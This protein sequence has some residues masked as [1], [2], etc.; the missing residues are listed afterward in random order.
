MKRLGFLV[1]FPLVFLLSSCR[2]QAAA[3]VAL[4]T[5]VPAATA[6]TPTAPPMPTP[7]PTHGPTATSTPTVPPTPTA[8]PTVVLPVSNGTPLPPLAPIGDDWGKVREV[9]QYAPHV[10]AKVVY[11]GKYTV[12]VYWKNLDIVGEDGRVVAHVPLRVNPAKD[13]V[14]TGNDVVAVASANTKTIHV[15][16]WK[17]KEI[18]QI[19]PH[20]EVQEVRVSP[21]GTLVAYTTR[22]GYDPLDWWFYVVSV[23]D[24]EVR[25]RQ[26][27]MGG[28]QFSEDGRYFAVFFDRRLHVYDVRSGRE[29]YNVWA[30][31][32]DTYAFSPNGEKVAVYHPASKTVE[33]YDHGELKR[34]I[35]Q[36]RWG[37]QGGQPVQ[38]WV[39]L[40]FSQ[41]GDVLAVLYTQ[42]QSRYAIFDLTT[43][44]RLGQAAVEGECA[45]WGI[46]K[47]YLVCKRAVGTR[48]L[49]GSPPQLF[50][51]TAQGW[52]MEWVGLNR[53]LYTKGGEIDCRSALSW[54]DETAPLLKSFG[55]PPWQMPYWLGMSEDGQV[56]GA[57][58]VSGRGMNT[59]VLVQTS[60]KRR[61][62]AHTFANHSFLG[63]PPL[64][65]VGYALAPQGEALALVGVS[66]VLDDLPA[67]GEVRFISLKRGIKLDSL[68]IP[69]PPK[70]VWGEPH[71]PIAFCGLNYLAVAVEGKPL[72]IYNLQ[73][74]KVV[75]ALKGLGAVHGLTCGQNALAVLDA[76]MVLHVYGIPALDKTENNP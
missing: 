19:T 11:S 26:H 73:T 6:V 53:C 35:H 76:S 16:N 18:S 27:A 62:W 70:M 51:S 8:T 9:A 33:V 50:I 56:K 15:Y 21:D 41:S 60:D 44:K 28:I 65:I 64:L 20:D 55:A 32:G 72:S 2:G 66:G 29:A 46:E 43:G 34:S 17:G 69:T 40:I 42:D 24:G 75:R 74:G 23:S 10:P 57:A 37:L 22:K 58:W 38:D 14:A 4:P 3:P 59:D 52:K 5:S 1:L 45:R 25:F 71:V 36:N 63:Y 47:G 48:A 54:G 7:T 49:G 68:V 12:L 39:Q 61:I 31:W 67:R 30:D 13:K